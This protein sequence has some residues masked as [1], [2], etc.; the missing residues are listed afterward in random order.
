MKCNAVALVGKKYFSGSVWKSRE[1]ERNLRGAAPALDQESDGGRERAPSHSVSAKGAV[2]K[3]WF[4]ERAAWRRQGAGAKP[5]NHSE[6]AEPD[7]SGR[8]CLAAA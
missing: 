6:G 5:F 1:G 2:R 3:G 4:G 8:S 7:G